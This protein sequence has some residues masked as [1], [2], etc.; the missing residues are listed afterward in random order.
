MVHS[1]QT[2]YG[3]S[4]ETYSG[5]LWVIKVNPPPQGL[6]QGNGAAHLAP[7]P[8]SALQWSM[9]SEKKDME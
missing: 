1:V 7:G 4:L 9:L 6:S 3:N 8:S 5:D 2:A